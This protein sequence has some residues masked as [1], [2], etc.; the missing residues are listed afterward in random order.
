MELKLIRNALQTPDGTIIESRSRHDYVTHTDANGK[1]YVVDGGLDYQRR[2][3]HGDEQDCSVYD[4]GDHLVRRE[5]LTWG[6]YGAAGDQTLTVTTIADMSTDH[7]K[8]VI[9]NCS[10]Y[11]NLLIKEVMVAELDH[12]SESIPAGQLRLV[13]DLVEGDLL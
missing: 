4:T 2:S 5:A 11:M 13:D 3:N 10:S 8:A 6:S 12:R 1:V 9:R 7:I